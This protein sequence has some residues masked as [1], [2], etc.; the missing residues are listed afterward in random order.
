MFGILEP[1]VGPVLAA[2]GGF[3]NTIAHGNAVA[4]PRFTG[5][6]PNNLGIRPVNGDSTDRLHRLLVEYW[7][8]SEPSVHG[9]PD[10]AAG[11]PDE[12]SE[13]SILSNGINGGN[14]AAPDGGA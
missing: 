9:F 13:P 12:H 5:P 1:N 10:A 3:V 2:I 7:L 14:A 6:R 11:R 8:K 4:R